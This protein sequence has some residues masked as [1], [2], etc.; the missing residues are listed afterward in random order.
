MYCETCGEEVNVDTIAVNDGTT[1]C[2]EECLELWQW[3]EISYEGGE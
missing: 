3:A 2:S 1:W